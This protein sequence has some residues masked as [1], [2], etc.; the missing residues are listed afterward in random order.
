MQHTTIPLND[1]CTDEQHYSIENPFFPELLASERNDLRIER[2]SVS[3]R[4][5]LCIKSL[6]AMEKI[7][8]AHK[9]VDCLGLYGFIVNGDK[10]NMP[11]VIIGAHNYPKKC[12]GL[13]QGTIIGPRNYPTENLDALQGVIIEST[14]NSNTATNQLDN[15][16]KSVQLLGFLFIEIFRILWSINEH[17][18]ASQKRNLIHNGKLPASAFDSFQFGFRNQYNNTMID[19]ASKNAISTLLVSM[20][21]FDPAKRPSIAITLEGFKA[22]KKNLQF[23]DIIS[24]TP[25]KIE[26]QNEDLINMIIDAAQNQKFIIANRK[27]IQKIKSQMTEYQ[28][29]II[30]PFEFRII[31]TDSIFKSK[32]SQN[33]PSFFSAAHSHYQHPASL[34]TSEAAAAST[35]N[36][37]L[38]STPKK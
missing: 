1:L 7:N 30:A 22:I 17:E 23:I 26:K 21:L 20:C 18:C 37:A 15:E 34:T 3:Q 36:T 5:Q 12:L 38:S 4:L 24:H 10:N 27:Y 33:H 19:D 28:L 9:Q 6:E 8:Q 13:L 11:K 14:D 2:L 31:L 25:T 16:K 29:T 35:P 32:A